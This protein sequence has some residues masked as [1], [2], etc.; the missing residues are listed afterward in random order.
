MPIRGRQVQVRFCGISEIKM[1]LHAA[2][3]LLRGIQIGSHP[4][5]V[6]RVEQN[7]QAEAGPL[8]RDKDSKSL[9]RDFR[10][11]ALSSD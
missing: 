1:Y 10:C 7:P 3:I 11:Q 2:F 4:Q 9:F 5:T 8:I 6:R